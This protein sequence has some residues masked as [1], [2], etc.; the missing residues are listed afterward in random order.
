MSNANPTNLV[1]FGRIIRIHE[2][3]H[4]IVIQ[5]VLLVKIYYFKPVR[6]SR[7]SILNAKII[8]LSMSSGIQI[9]I[10]YEFIVEMTSKMHQT[11]K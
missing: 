4:A 11:K 7:N 2:R 9:C 1:Q 10:E 8:P 3:F 5:T 6:D